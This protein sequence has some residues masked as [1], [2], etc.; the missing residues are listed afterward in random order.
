[1]PQ[2]QC[3]HKGGL[4][5]MPK[6]WVNSL[7]AMPFTLSVET[8]Y[9]LFSGS[10]TADQLLGPERA[11]DLRSKKTGYSWK[12]LSGFYKK[13]GGQGY[14]SVKISGNGGDDLFALRDTSSLSASSVR[15][16]GDRGGDM[17]IVPRKDLDTDDI[18]FLGGNGVDKAY[19]FPDWDYVSLS[20][21]KLTPLYFGNG[22]TGLLVGSDVE[23]ISRFIGG[24]E[25]AI[26]TQ[27]LLSA[28]LAAVSD[29]NPLG[30][31]D[32]DDISG[33]PPPPVGVSIAYQKDVAGR[34]TSQQADLITGLLSGLKDKSAIV[35]DLDRTPDQQAQRMLDGYFYGK[36]NPGQTVNAGVAALKRLYP[37]GA[38]KEL[39]DYW[40][41]KL[42]DIAPSRMVGESDKQY[43]KRFFG[44]AFAER[45]D[46]ITEGGQLIS[47]L[48]KE[49]PA[50]FRHIR[51]KG[52]SVR[53]VDIA[54]S[55]IAEGS[56][57]GFISGLHALE[58]LG[59]VNRSLTNLKSENAY[60]IEFYV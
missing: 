34:L 44:A 11:R 27:E 41:K 43:E 5:S 40:E 26:P 15:I 47:K 46:L 28:C 21:S 12:S 48:I 2:L 22:T 37:S 52:L 35:S 58:E 19:L 56:R 53:A 13:N 4:K 36:K 17:L 54:P 59:L 33:S 30:D 38:G 23:Y 25:V 57:Q 18:R 8:P 32:L 24:K 42:K 49:Y 45:T 14:P 7:E 29:G 16:T 6:T 39:V 31:V 20:G 9:V 1:M 51:R 50:S 55:S 10:N 3:I 60:H